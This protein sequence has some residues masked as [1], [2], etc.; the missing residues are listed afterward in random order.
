[1]A[2]FVLQNRHSSIFRITDDV[3]GAHNVTNSSPATFLAGVIVNVT[4]GDYQVQ[5]LD[6]DTLTEVAPGATVAIDPTGV[7][8]AVGVG[9]VDKS[10]QA[11]ATAYNYVVQ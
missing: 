9:F 10:A 6:A 4:R 3:T 1:M 11:T 2:D 7:S 5:E 8:G